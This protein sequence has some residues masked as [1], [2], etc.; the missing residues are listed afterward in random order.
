M[1]EVSFSLHRK[2][3]SKPLDKAKR[4]VCAVVPDSQDRVIRHADSVGH[5]QQIITAQ[6]A[7]FAAHKV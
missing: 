7:Q 2:E 5:M 3:F 1:L 4:G 6:V